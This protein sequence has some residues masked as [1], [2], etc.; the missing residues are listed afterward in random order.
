MWKWRY[1]YDGCG[2]LRFPTLSVEIPS[3]KGPL[4]VR[5]TRGGPS[6][7][8]IYVEGDSALP[9]PAIIDE[10]MLRVHG[11]VVV[12]CQA[13]IR[14]FSIASIETV[15]ADGKLH[16]NGYFRIQ[17]AAVTVIPSEHMTDVNED[18]LDKLA[19]I[20]A[21]AKA[22]K[23]ALL[24]SVQHSLTQAEGNVE[25][26]LAN[27]SVLESVI[28]KQKGVD[29]FLRRVETEV[30]I[31]KDRGNDVTIY[32]SLRNAKGHPS[33]MRPDVASAKIGRLLPR[34]RQHVRTALLE[35]ATR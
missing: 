29:D 1:K 30:E 31:V 4:L 24:E 35:S 3:S 7:V 9:E 33:G 23:P 28:G 22:I 10:V 32:T 27:Y 25:A 19:G 2:Y 34:L 15:D 17:D 20:L 13:A 16:F 26:F 14:K 21:T 18:E 8:Y 5:I 12:F 6:R 11:L